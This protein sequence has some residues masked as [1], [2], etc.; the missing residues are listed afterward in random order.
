[1]ERTRLTSSLLNLINDFE[2]SLTEGIDTVLDEKAYSQIVEYYVS[3][4][5]LDR[6]IEVA[7]RAINQYPTHTDFLKLKA[8]LLLKSREYEDAHDILN[9][10]ELHEPF[11]VDILLMRARALGGQAKFEEAF[12]IIEDVKTYAKKDEEVKAFLTESEVA[13]VSHDFEL[14]FQALKNALILDPKNLKA[15]RLMKRA[16]NL[17]RHFEESILLHR[18]IVEN[19]PYSALAWYNL[20]H[21]FAY[22]SE[23]DNAIEALEYAFLVDQSFEEAYYDCAEFCVEIEDY[24]RAEIILQEASSQFETNYDTLYSISLCR[25]KIGKVEEAKR[26]LFEAMQLEPYCE[27]LHFLLAKCYIKDQNWTGA[28]NMLEKALE[29]EDQIED[30]YFYLARI[31]E[32][33]NKKAKANVFYRKAAFQGMEQ[34][35]YWEEYIMY[36]IKTNEFDLAKKYINVSSEHT[37][38]SKIGYLDI[39]IKLLNGKRDEGLKLLTE[40][41]QED[42]DGKKVLLDI[43]DTI[44]NDREVQSIISYYEKE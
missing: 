13:E 38:S 33:I 10:A 34:S 40:I 32:K 7:Q 39:A 11:N 23:Y 17:S 25:Y 36:L 35:F 9:R 41:I 4:S 20:G 14:M 22:V 2:Q 21:S 26:S 8:N 16:I 37:Y 28:I 3:E 12:E 44:K 30:Y 42:L 18:V 29:L 1:M 15:L 19:H 5:R 6:A 24:Q 43:D 31:Y 27:E